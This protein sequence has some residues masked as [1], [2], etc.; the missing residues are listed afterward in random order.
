MIWWQ[1][2]TK[3]TYEAL[4]RATFVPVLPLPMSRSVRS[5]TWCRDGLTQASTSFRKLE[6]QFP[7]CGRGRHRECE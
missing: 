6:L 5:D 1:P 7:N 2:C 4:R 3:S